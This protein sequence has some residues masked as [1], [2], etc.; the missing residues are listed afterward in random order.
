[1]F[2][3]FRIRSFALLTG[4]LFLIISCASPKAPTGGVADTAPPAIIEEES[5]PNRQT[6]FQEDEIIL[7]FDEWVTLKDVYNQLIVSPIMPE[8][9]EIK[10][11]GKAIVITLPDSLRDETTYTI[12][13]G[14]AITD[15]NEGNVLDNYVFVFSTGASLDSIKI[16]G[17]VI[18]AVTLKP[19]DDIW[20]MLYTI[21]EDSAVYKRKPDYIAK[22]N[23]TGNWNMSFLPADSFD[24][25]GLKDLNVNFLFDQE[26][27]S[28]GWLNDPIYTGDEFL[29]V[30][31][32][33]IFP[34]ENRTVIKEVIHVSPGYMK[35]IV[36]APLPKPVPVLLPE[37]DSSKT[38]WSGDTLNVWYDP[39]VNYTG[40][41]VLEN[42][43]TVVRAS[44]QPSNQSQPLSIKPITG[45]LKPGGK[46]N[47]ILNS[48]VASIDTSRILLQHDS[49]GR[50]PFQ[51]ERDSNDIRKILVSGPWVG[52]FRYPIIFYPGAITDFWGRVNDTVRH[53]FVV[54]GADQFGDLTM[55]IDSLDP[56]KQYVIILKEGEQ[57]NDTFVVENSSSAQIVKQGLHPA[58][59]I[60]EVIEDLNRNRGWDTGSYERRRQP[61]RKLI[62]TPEN[63]R[64]GWEQEVKMIWKK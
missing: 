3:S 2:I 13:F 54:S 20:V 1:M 9:P 29:E 8:E 27:E 37:I 38:L 49:L 50:I 52:E 47:F 57:I 34:R 17:A 28:I 46:M 44:T 42:D 60:I 5:T 32:I 56:T 10:Q 14:D 6:N 15:L 43:S 59:Y 53:S 11:K 58:K 51:I 24:I 21:G 45:R 22:S 40:Y 30:P 12:N 35:I 19:A 41:V 48:P 55:S 16:S 36:D 18:D 39:R 64:A 33:Y 4:I 31:P 25:V 61:E 63:L 26:G 62:F 7:I 23:E